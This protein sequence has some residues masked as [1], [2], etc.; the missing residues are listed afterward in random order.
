MWFK[1]D[2]HPA[3]WFGMPGETVVLNHADA[4]GIVLDDGDSDDFMFY[5]LTF[6]NM[7]RY[8]VTVSDA[9]RIVFYKCTFS[10]GNDATEGW[11]SSFIRGQGT[12]SAS[13]M[14]SI[15]IQDCT[16]DT[17]T[18]YFAGIKLYATRHVLIEDC[19]FESI[20]HEPVAIKAVNR[21][22]TIRHNT[23]NDCDALTVEGINYSTPVNYDFEIIFNYFHDS[24]SSSSAY[25]SR[26][27]AI[28][29]RVDS[30]TGGTG[31]T[32]VERNTIID[33]C[34]FSRWDSTND[35]PLYLKNNIIES[36]LSDSGS[37]GSNT[38]YRG[39]SEW[40]D[41]GSS[42][43][44][45]ST[46][47]FF[48]TDYTDNGGTDD[49]LLG[50]KGAYVDSQGDLLPAHSDYVGEK[51]WQTQEGVGGPPPASAPETPNGLEISK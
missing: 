51:G 7:F 25:H 12:T 9:L 43:W 23:F 20:N 26:T 46:G 15:F 8:A 17:T 4:Y 3:G 41:I 10:N 36:S 31:T 30:N 14:S 1:D 29:I 37:V 42:K 28:N 34:A 11:N 47:I 19:A 13:P 5:N 50:A 21:N 24:Q 32:Y 27:F 6:N 16:F 22:V 48:G 45:S 18:N 38:W 40:N 39:R 49:N 33:P 2:Y 35:G 44:N